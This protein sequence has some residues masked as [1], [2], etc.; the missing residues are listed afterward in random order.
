VSIHFLITLQ[1]NIEAVICHN[2]SQTLAAIDKRLEELQDELLK[3]ASSKA[4]YG[5]DRR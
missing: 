3:L 1:N 5:K 2:N 4:D